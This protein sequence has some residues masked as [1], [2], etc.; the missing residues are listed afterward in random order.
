[1]LKLLDVLLT[2]LHLVIILFNLFGWMFSS[3]RKLHLISIILTA[4]SWFILGIWFGMGYCPITDW[5]WNV[6]EKLGEHNL[7]SN[8]IE[9]FAEKI[10]GRDLSSQLI[11]TAIAVCFALAAILSVYVNFIRKH[12]RHNVH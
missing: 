3:T 10:S 11:N 2:I 1:M 8:F 12:L 6:K 4:A 5:Q 7:P 9:Y